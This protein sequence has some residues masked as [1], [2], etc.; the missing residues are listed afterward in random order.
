MFSDLFDWVCGSLAWMTRG[1]VIYPPLSP[2]RDEG[3]AKVEEEI[4]PL[5]SYPQFL[6]MP[7]GIYTM[8]TT[9]V[10]FVASLAQITL[11]V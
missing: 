1:G 10:H 11:F 4:C 5:A 6:T 3:G 2:E 9:L 8:L 7:L